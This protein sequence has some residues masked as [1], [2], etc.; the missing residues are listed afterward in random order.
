M[1]RCQFIEDHRK[2]FKDQQLRQVLDV[3]RSTYYK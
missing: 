1:N 3:G 2:T